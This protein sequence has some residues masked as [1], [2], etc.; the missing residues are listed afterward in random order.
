MREFTL[1][2]RIECKGRHYGDKAAS[3]A[4]AQRKLFEALG[5]LSNVDVVELEMKTDSEAGD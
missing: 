4:Y 5:E 1:T 2:L 3:E